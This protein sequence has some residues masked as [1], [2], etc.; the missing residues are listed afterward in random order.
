M[1][2]IWAVVRSDKVDSI[3]RRLKQIGVSGCTVTRVR[4]YGEE[5]HLYE[6][7]IHGG[8]H[9]LE[10]IV[11]DD[12]ADNV[13][14]EIVEHATTGLEGDG[15]LSIF[16]LSSVVNIHSKQQVKNS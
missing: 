4:G 7:L 11:E 3:A 10:A 8:H 13:V 15:I 12:Q 6:P 5:W 2:M 9:K 1:K 14:K 16:D